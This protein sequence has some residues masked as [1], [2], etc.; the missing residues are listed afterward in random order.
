MD[1]QNSNLPS[2]LRVWDDRLRMARR[3][4]ENAIGLY[5]RRAEGAPYAELADLATALASR[6]VT[7]AR[8]AEGA[9]AVVDAVEELGVPAE[10]APGEALVRRLADVD[11]SLPPSEVKPLIEEA[12]QLTDAAPE[13]PPRR[14]AACAHLDVYEEDEPC[15]SCLADPARPAWTSARGVKHQYCA[16]CQHSDA[17]RS[18]E[19]CRDCFVSAENGAHLAWAPKREV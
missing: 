10:P 6:A 9:R 7:V 19:P 16:A 4:L 5:T 2:A 12:R 8:S 3:Q 17:P 1:S 13:Q 14:C 18:A 15:G 11:D